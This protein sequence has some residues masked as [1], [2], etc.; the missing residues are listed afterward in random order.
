METEIMTQN[1]AQQIATENGMTFN[2]FAGRCL[3]RDLNYD[4]ARAVW[5]NEAGPRGFND[6]TKRIVSKVLRRPV[7]EIFPA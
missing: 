2:Q 3:L 5:Y 4:T 6:R 1:K 7:D